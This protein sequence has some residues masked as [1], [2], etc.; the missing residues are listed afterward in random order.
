[1][2][3]KEIVINNCYG[4][5]SLSPLAIKEWAKLKNKECYF[6]LNDFVTDTFIPITMQE[7]NKTILFY[8]FSVPNPN[9]VLK[10]PVK[11]EDKLN[12]NLY[13]L[14]KFN[15]E[16]NKKYESINIWD[17]KIPRD[18]KDL[19]AVVK[20]LGTKKASGKCNAR[21]FSCGFFSYTTTVIYFAKCKKYSLTL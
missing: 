7:A 17:S 19:I 13:S 18:D 5:F 21:R 6:F 16:Y 14:L 4:G 10:L 12:F 2:K 3:E 20:K 15:S 9:E 8:T 1:M 11:I